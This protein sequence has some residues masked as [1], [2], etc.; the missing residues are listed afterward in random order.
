[1]CGEVLVPRHTC[2]AA[3]VL[4]YS[5]GDALVR[6]CTPPQYLFGDTCSAKYWFGD[7]PLFPFHHQSNPMQSNAMQ[8]YPIQFN[9]IQLSNPIQSNPMQ[10]HPLQSSPIQWAKALGSHGSFSDFLHAG[11]YFGSRWLGFFSDS[12]MLEVT[13]K[14]LGG[15]GWFSDSSAPGCA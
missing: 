2:L 6:R 5:F 10:S 14:G 13:L 11:R 15:L 7:E 4:Q 9:P 3:L 12:Y 8:S 1:M